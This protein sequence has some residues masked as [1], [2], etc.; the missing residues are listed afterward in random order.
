MK[1]QNR[2]AGVIMLEA[3]ILMP[4]FILLML[5]LYAFFI[6]F[7]GQQIMSHTAIQTA[8]SLSFDPYAVSRVDGNNLAVMIGD[9]TDLFFDGNYSSTEVWHTSDES[10]RIPETARK[11]FLAYLP[12]QND[13]DAL[14]QWIGVEN[15]TAG[16]DFSGSTVED[17]VLT[18]K[19]KYVQNFAFKLAELTSFDRGI[20]LKVKLLVWNKP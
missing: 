17:G 7:M 15:G 12:N 10:D 5:F 6:F 13:P 2:N 19:I 1:K 16:L 11:R 20:T 14:L 18:L 8:K 4:L 9:I 3:A